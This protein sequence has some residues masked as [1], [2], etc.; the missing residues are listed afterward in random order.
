MAAWEDFFQSAPED[1]AKTAGIHFVDCEHGMVGIVSSVDVLALNRVLG[2]GVRRDGSPD[3][4]LKL[5]QEYDRF[6]VSRFFVQLAPIALPTT[7]GADLERYG[8]R[9][10]NNW[11]RLIRGTEKRPSLDTG[12]DVRTI[13]EPEA[14]TFG[15]LVCRNFGWPE[16]LVPWVAASVGRPNWTHYMAY[17]GQTPIATAAMFRRGHCAWLDLATT[18]KDHRGRGCQSALLAIRINDAA[19]AGCNLLTLETADKKLGILAPAYRNA[20]R[21]GFRVAYAR[22]NYIWE[23]A[24][25]AG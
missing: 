19:D 2:L 21:M 22:P 7:L 5:I 8:L 15:S 18:E 1:M 17:D 25:T 13:A 24:P 20:V 11:I 6:A 23:R 10:Y 4:P 12:L 16:T 14:L 3:A 9:Q